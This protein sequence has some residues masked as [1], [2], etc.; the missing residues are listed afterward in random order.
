MTSIHNNMGAMVAL[1]T[2]SNINYEM[3]ETQSAIATGKK[4][5]NAAQ[6]AAIWA[7]T[8]VM[9]ADVDG[10]SA[11]SESLSL[12][13]ATVTVARNASEK[14]TELLQDMKEKIVTAQGENV[15]RAKIQTDIDELKNQIES[16]VG[17]AQFNGLNLID[18]SVSDSIEIISSLDRSTSGVKTNSIT[19]S[20]QN[21][22][23]GSAKAGSG[24]AISVTAEDSETNAAV[25][26][27][28]ANLQVTWANGTSTSAVE[29][30]LYVD[31]S[32]VGST[33]EIAAGSTD[34]EIALAVQNYIADLGRDDIDATVIASGVQIDSTKKFD[35]VDVELKEL[36]S[37]ATTSATGADTNTTLDPGVSSVQ[38]KSSDTT[39]AT[40]VAAS[41]TFDAVNAGD[42]F[43]VEIGGVSLGTYT[44]DGTN[45]A[46][47]SAAFTTFLNSAIAADSNLNGKLT[48]VD[49]TTDTVE[50]INNTGENFEI[51]LTAV[52]AGGGSQV[53]LNESNT[54]AA[55][56]TA[57]GVL[58][59]DGTNSGSVDG[60]LE[61]KGADIDLGSVATVAEGDSFT[62][63]LREGADGPVGEFTYVAGKGEDQN[64]VAEGLQ[65]LIAADSDY[66]VF[67]KA[68][69]DPNDATKALLRIDSTGSEDVY[70]AV[71]AAK[72][73]SGSGG[74]GK[75]AGLDVTS[76]QSAAQALDDIEELIQTS[77]DA[78]AAF[79]STENR[80]SIQADFV[81]SLIDS[82]NSGIGA[83]VDT[84]MEAAS[85]RLQALQV[86]QQLGTQALSIANSAPQN[87]LSLFR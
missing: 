64:D 61:G 50:L 24:A 30:E 26:P 22:S 79:G 70:V 34:E 48:A 55:G 57:A 5:D 25:T 33:V 40:T 52:A 17:A 84:D 58:V 7:V 46:T 51:K 82:M 29:Y 47:D 14:V 20:A 63:Y 66:D 72:G 73:G 3:L 31:G 23:T 41:V 27:N 83:L 9:E 39:D 36:K 60:T 8:T 65:A 76:T 43:T 2:L 13:K 74:L 37:D 53:T 85:A 38:T 69:T 78:A 42:Q 86:Q 12:G 4:V 67:V 77:I 16:I 59:I 54:A 6:D 10:F 81:S 18:G 49:D 28:S 35:T 87:I 1:S 44:V 62:V 32:S 15:D 45:V 21:L 68:Y 11:I 56:T 19:V 75:L 71:D 80:I